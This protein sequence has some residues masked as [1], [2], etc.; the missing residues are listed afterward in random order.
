MPSQCNAY[1]RSLSFY[2]VAVAAA[3]DAAAAVAA[4]D[5]D[6]AATADASFE[7]SGDEVLPPST[8]VDTAMQL[9]SWTEMTKSTIALS[10]E[11]WES[12]S[13]TRLRDQ[14]ISHVM[15]MHS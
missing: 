14:R 13:H 6:T 11:T 10:V 2:L 9:A 7:F 1:E 8:Y 3:A 5:A 12:F 15:H 4:G